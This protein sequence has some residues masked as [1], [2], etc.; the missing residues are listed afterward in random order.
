MK[1]RAEETVFGENLQTFSLLSEMLC[2][3]VFQRYLSFEHCMSPTNW[4]GSI[5]WRVGNLKRLRLWRLVKHLDIGLSQE[6]V[7]WLRLFHHLLWRS[8]RKSIVGWFRRY[9]TMVKPQA[10][11]LRYLRLIFLPEQSFVRFL[12]IALRLLK[13]VLADGSVLEI[14]GIVIAINITWLLVNFI[15]MRPAIFGRYFGAILVWFWSELMG[16]SYWKLTC[17]FW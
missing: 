17:V 8:L 3:I 7:E 14:L 4:E 5:G 12:L 11:L 1:L 9:F 10:N 13:R 6:H 15:G 2:F 16:Q